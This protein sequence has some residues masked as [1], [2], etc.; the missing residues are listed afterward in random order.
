MAPAGLTLPQHSLHPSAALCPVLSSTRCTGAAIAP[1]LLARPCDVAQPD[2]VWAGDSMDLWTAA[3]WVSL[4]ALLDW[5]ARKVV[6]GDASANW[7][8]WGPRPHGGSAQRAAPTQWRQRGRG[9][10]E[11]GE[12][13]RGV[14]KRGGVSGRALPPSECC[15]RLGFRMECRSVTSGR[16]SSRGRACTSW[17]LPFGSCVMLLCNLYMGCLGM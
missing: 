8:Q 1:N 9:E 16:V 11:A 4:A 6:G 13:G 3:G 10:G 7:L 17:S 5:Y 14:V 15:Q 2:L 12:G